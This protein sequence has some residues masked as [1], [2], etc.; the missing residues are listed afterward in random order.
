MCRVPAGGVPEPKREEHVT[1]SKAV[2]ELF[3]GAGGLSEGLRQGGLPVTVAVDADSDALATH[4]LN[5]PGTLAYQ[6][7][8]HEY[9][10][11]D[12]QAD[13]ELDGLNVGKGDFHLVCGG[14]PCQGFSTARHAGR[15][16]LGW[17]SDRR[18]HL[19]DRLLDYADYFRPEFVLIE[20]VPGML[21]EPGV[22]A[23]VVA[24]LV[25]MGYHSRCEV[26]N[27]ADY[28]AAQRRERVFYLA[29]R[30][31]RPHYPVQT[32]SEVVGHRQAG[33]FSREPAVRPWETVGGV[34]LPLVGRS[35]LPNTDEPQHTQAMVER[36]AALEPGVGL[37]ES[38]R[39]SWVRLRK[40][41]PAPTVRESHGGSSVHPT[42]PRVLT[43][44]EMAALQ[45]FPLEYEFLGSVSSQRAQVGNAVQ[46]DVARALAGVLT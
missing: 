10:P 46:V 4:R 9:S 1:V 31:G 45:G 28:G 41:A 15:K 24:R 43:V 11:Q 35:D 13:L 23:H 26:L 19:V 8:L 33:L 30:S 29:Q 32:H 6:R 3:C 12:L 37:Y 27:S 14:P 7:D 17:R 34:L 2:L 36:L 40:D 39:S 22:V 5:H 44:R 21:R 16:H 42:E 38:Y 20:N 25:G 18:N